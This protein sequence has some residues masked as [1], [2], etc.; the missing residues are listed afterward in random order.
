MVAALTLLLYLLP[1]AFYCWCL[2]CLL[3]NRKRSWFY[4][5]QRGL[6][7]IALCVAPFPIW[8]ALAGSISGTGFSSIG[9]SLTQLALVPGSWWILTGGE[10]V[11]AIFEE[12]VKDW[13]GHRR[14]TMF[15]NLHVFALLTIAQTLI[16]SG[17]ASLRFHK[18]KNWRDPILLGIG[19]FSAI[20]A[21]MGMHW[22]WFG[23]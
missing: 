14:D 1:S 9:E 22:M 10:T 20:N 19:L 15:D 11:I 5:W 13:T 3:R 21:A 4:Q 7:W 16:L 2:A 12:N 17:I 6:G 18:G 23:T 8:Q